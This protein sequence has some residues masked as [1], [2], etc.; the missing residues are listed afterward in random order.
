MTT[1][2]QNPGGTQP[3]AGPQWPGDAGRGS[4]GDDHGGGMGVDPTAIK[5]GY[6]DDVKDIRGTLVM[7]LA[8]VVFFLIALGTVATLFAFFMG[9]DQ[10]RPPLNDRI[11]DVGKDPGSAG[12]QPRLE[13]IRTREAGDNAFPKLELTP[14]G[15]SRYANSPEYHAED[16][17]ADRQPLLQRTEGGR[18]PIDKALETAVKGGLFPAQKD[19]TP[20]AD[21]IHSPTAANAG[22]GAGDATAPEPD[23]KP[24]HH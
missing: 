19:V 21:M 1:N 18:L 8:V 10:P 22:R 13:A 15:G 9:S 7:P 4:A 11:A 20:V 5:R 23:K 14:P 6:E 3:G 16:L 24:A 12:P 17:R 2:D